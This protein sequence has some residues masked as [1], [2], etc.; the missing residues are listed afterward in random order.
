MEIASPYVLVVGSGVCGLTCAYLL[1]LANIQ[2][3]VIEKARGIG[4]RLSNR[5]LSLGQF[6][7][8]MQQISTELA[9]QPFVSKM[10]PKLKIEPPFQPKNLPS[11]HAFAQ[12][13]FQLTQQTPRAP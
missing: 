4:G 8:G 3:L 13:L 10:L 5:K 1:G 7:L 12:A 6:D 9:R 2:V 11:G